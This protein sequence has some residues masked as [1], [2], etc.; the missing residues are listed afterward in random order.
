MSSVEGLGEGPRLGF[1]ESE[2]RGI[3]RGVY[4]GCRFHEQAR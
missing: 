4:S 3:D 2:E 1:A